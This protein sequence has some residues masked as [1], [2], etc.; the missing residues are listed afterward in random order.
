LYSKNVFWPMIAANNRERL[1]IKNY[2]PVNRSLHAIVKLTWID[3]F[4]FCWLA[5]NWV[6]FE[7][8]NCPSS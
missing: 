8:E 3:L 5:S 4:S 7:F 6:E 2:F 1:L